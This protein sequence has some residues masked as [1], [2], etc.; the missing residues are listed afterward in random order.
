[1]FQAVECK[2]RVPHPETAKDSVG[3][4]LAHVLRPGSRKCE[5]LSQR[6]CVGLGTTALWSRRE[7]G[8]FWAVVLARYVISGTTTAHCG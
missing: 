1:M 6:G 4:L 2:W 7:K 5:E 3:D 8:G